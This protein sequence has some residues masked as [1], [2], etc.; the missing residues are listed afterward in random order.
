MVTFDA[1]SAFRLP[2]ATVAVALDIG[3]VGESDLFLVY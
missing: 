2:L 1:A 3:V